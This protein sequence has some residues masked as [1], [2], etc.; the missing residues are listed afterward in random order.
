MNDLTPTATM[1]P[2]TTASRDLRL[3][4]ERTHEII[5]ELVMFW[6]SD[7]SA[8]QLRRE[9]TTTERKYLHMRQRDLFAMLRGLNLEERKHAAK[10]IA[11]MFLGFPNLRTSDNQ[12]TVAAYIMALE[13]FP[14][15]AII[16]A[17]MDVSQRRV[18]DISPDFAPSAP[19]LCELATRHL[20]PLRGELALIEKTITAKYEQEPVPP[21]E[22]ERI[23]VKLRELADHMMEKDRIQRREHMTHL[24]VV[25]KEQGTK[26]ILRE[27]SRLGIEP[28]YADADCKILLSPELAGKKKIP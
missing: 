2:N 13:A 12:A 7:A 26:S 19:R 28:V 11:A 21:E 20:V 23:K 14:L 9:I 18:S 24:S 6:P 10:A 25:L 27:Y 17:C 22:R 16:E 15:F 4:D 5:E 1:T 3:R 8:V